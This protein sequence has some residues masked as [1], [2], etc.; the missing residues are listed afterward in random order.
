MTGQRG[1]D[2]VDSFSR[3]S[4]L[5]PR[6][7]EDLPDPP[8]TLYF[9][10]S[11]F[12][13]N[14][15][16]VA[17]VGARKASSYG[18]AMAQALGRDLACTGLAVISGMAHGIDA[19]AHRGALEADGWTIAVLAAGAG[20]AYPP[21]NG[22]LYREIVDSGGLV[23]SEEPPGT[24]NQGWRFLKRNR[25]IAALARVTIVVEA[26]Q[27][28]GALATAAHARSMGRRLGAVPGRVGSPHAAGP[29]AL[30]AAGG[31]VIRG[32]QDV[33]DVLYGPGTLAAPERSR[34]PLDPGQAAVLD[35]IADGYDSAA[36]LSRAGIE[37]EQGLATLAALELGGHIVRGPGGRFTVAA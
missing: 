20:E 15:E 11:P 31:S 27:R 1:H 32:V 8:P 29:N 6:A 5:Y 28:S 16:A 33:F 24:D 13:L 3:G 10:G 4:A 21:S 26:S 18:L 30:L 23:I 25:I 34:P 9:A 7:L 35:A 36:A 17:I 22:P 14:H 2:G 19:A 12:R 37:P